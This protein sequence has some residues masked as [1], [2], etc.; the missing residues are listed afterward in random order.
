MASPLERAI[1]FFSAQ[2]ASAATGGALACLLAVIARAMVGIHPHS[3]MGKPPMYGDFEAQRHWMEITTALPVLEWY[4]DTPSNNLTYWGLDYPPLTAYHS[5][6]NG[7][8]LGWA[9]PASMELGASHGHET[10][11]FRALMRLTVLLA[12]VLIFFPA[13][14]VFVSRFYPGANRDRRLWV[15]T[16]ILMQPALILID[17]GHFQYNTVSLGLVT[18]SLAAFAPGLAA[19]AGDN[20]YAPS[21][22]RDAVGAAAF[23]LGLYYKQMCLYLAWPIFICLLSKNVRSTGP[24]R[25]ILVLAC[26]VVATTVA[27]WWPFLAR[28]ESEDVLHVIRRLFPFNRGL[29]ED[30]VANVWCALSLVLKFDRILAAATMIRVCAVVT[31]VSVLPSTLLLWRRPTSS[32]LLHACVCCGLS[33]FLFSFQVHEKS[34]LLPLLPATLLLGATPFASGWFITV[35]TFSMFPLLE[36]DGLTL[37]YLVLVVAF[38]AFA[39][40]QSPAGRWGPATTCRWLSNFTMLAIHCVAW[41]TEPPKRY[42]DLI[43]YLF[44]ICSCVHFVGFWMFHLS[45]QWEESRT[46]ADSVLEGGR[47]VRPLRIAFV[48]PDLGIGGAERLVVDAAVGLQKFDHKVT[49]YTAH[50]DPGHSFEETNDGTLHVV[51]YGDW[52]PTAFCRRFMAVCA[53]VRVFWVSMRVVGLSLSGKIDVIVVDQVSHSIPLLKSLTGAKIIFYCHYPDYLL[54]SRTSCCKKIYRAPL[55]LAEEMTTGMADKILVNS[56][57]TA[58]TFASSFRS[59]DRRGIKPDVLY[60]AINIKNQDVQ[61]DE[62]TAENLDFEGND[63]VLSI[64]RFERKK[65]IGLAVEALVA[66]SVKG[67][68]KGRKV[69]LVVAGG[70]DPRVDE[71]AEVKLELEEAASKAGLYTDGGTDNRVRFMTNISNE[72]K[73]RLLQ[74]A[75]C[76]LYTPDREHFGIVPVEAMYAKC[77]VIAVNS[78]GPLESIIDFQPL[79]PAGNATG[80]LRPQDP[81]QWADAMGLLLDDPKLKESMGRAGHQRVLDNFSLESFAQSLD[82]HITKTFKTLDADDARKKQ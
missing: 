33:F 31:F 24:V 70:F 18:L 73:L 1:G 46:P 69:V 8:M 60:P 4:R 67:G 38:N 63:I 22:L 2:G 19:A 74:R 58:E 37:P 62:K 75:T 81:E 32:N 35:A 7:K 76:L 41:F 56:L 64:N 23:C 78:G 45:K 17:H 49:L 20:A 15:L 40:A 16:G 68:S 66:L 54:T 34:I 77:P 13:A 27:C 57:F 39:V 65:N 36:R 43:T 5:W 59:L 10:P 21:G 42:P 48:H 82:D 28:S 52:L 79:K 71:N 11:G 47:R 53:Y 61:V 6:V 44:V 14:S 80:F 55:D 9:S 3:G 51:V 72:T 12:D 29:Y 26:C 30:K 25:G 50:H